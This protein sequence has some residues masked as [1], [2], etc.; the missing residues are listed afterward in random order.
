MYIS[1][2][3]Q[4]FTYLTREYNPLSFIESALIKN[5]NKAKKNILIATIYA[6]KR[7]LIYFKL[8]SV[9]KMNLNEKILVSLTISKNV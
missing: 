5:E 3:N 8:F 2:L 4:V 7:S 1:Y 9:L 6:I